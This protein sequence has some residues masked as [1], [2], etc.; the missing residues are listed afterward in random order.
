MLTK[1]TFV[2]MGH[3]IHFLG[4]L[5]ANILGEDKSFRKQQL[6]GHVL[7]GEFEEMRIL[8][9][10]T[11]IVRY[12]GAFT[13]KQEK[14][15]ISLRFM[16]WSAMSIFLPAPILDTSKTERRPKQEEHALAEHCDKCCPVRAG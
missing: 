9:V 2:S 7:E 1:E 13:V 14:E 3:I 5:Y 6:T 15:L 8:E 11:D 16:F 10:M 12:N 4:P